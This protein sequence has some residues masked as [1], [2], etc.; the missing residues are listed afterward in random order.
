MPSRSPQ[1]PI[2]AVSRLTGLSVDTLRAWERRYA[3][4]TPVRDERGRT[5]SSED[6]ER[7]KILAQLVGQGHAI[8]RIAALPASALHK[9]LPASSAPT[10]KAH[11]PI[12]VG[13]LVDAAKRYDLT[14]VDSILSRHALLLQ[15]TDL[16]FSVVLPLLKEVG[17][18]WESGTLRASQE[19]LLSAVIRSV[20]GSLLRTFPRLPRI[21]GMAMATVSG[22]RHELGL[23][24][25]A[26][27]AAS[28]GTPVTY[29][30]AD[31]PAHDLVH[32]VTHSDARVLVTSATIR[33]AVDDHEW[34]VLASLPER[35]QIWVGGPQS[36]E[37]KRVL[38]SRARIIASLEDFRSLI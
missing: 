34:K 7:L 1:Y 14:A 5:Y 37:A 15:P 35:I 16:I 18:R 28:A 36:E 13:P 8:G 25:C 27:L 32:A 11:A 38:K 20:L 22:E 31:L 19:H 12:D 10:A 2:R 3:A 9:L 30:G 26:V 4:V 21:P 33:G 23:L 17:E 29:L 6:V 24:C